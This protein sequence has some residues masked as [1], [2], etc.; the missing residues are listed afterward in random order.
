MALKS[1]TAGSGIRGR[2]LIQ[3]LGELQ[4]LQVSVLTGANAAT[5]I[6]LAGITTTDTILA[7]ILVKDP[8]AATTASVVKLTPSIPSN[9]NVQF[10]EA[11]NGAAGD[12]VV[13]LWF[14]K[15]TL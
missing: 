2:D 14:D 11:T 9:G 12:R 13:V 6:A 5:P 15:P 3:A 10:A 1:V 8:G 7:A 4:G